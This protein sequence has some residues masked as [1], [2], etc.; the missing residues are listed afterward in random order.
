MMKASREAGLP[1][2][3]CFAHTLQLV[4]NE[5][6]LSQ[7]AV[8]DILAISRKIVGHFKHSTLAYHRLNEIQDKLSMDKHRL[9]QDEPT[10]W[11]SSLYMLQ[12]IYTQKMALAAY[13]TEY[14]SIN[15]LTTHQL[16]LV[17][18]II[19]VL[20]P[21]EEITK[22][23]STDAASASVLI[24][25]LRALEKSLS[26]HHDDSGIQTMKSEM[27]SSLKRRYADVEEREELII[28]TTMD[29]RYKDKFFSKPT[30]KVFVKNL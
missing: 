30:T 4:V 18:K 25:L 16:E 10:R 23:I 7:R 27:L 21:V 20:E 15:M 9:V 8:I 11:N 29:P 17:R 5:G 14:D 26:K 1:S 2:M 19:A 12:S 22:L 28:A 3:G 13:A 6:V 24:P